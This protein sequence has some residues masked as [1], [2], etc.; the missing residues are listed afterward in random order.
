MLYVYMTFTT[1]IFHLS[2]FNI[3]FSSNNFNKKYNFKS[4]KKLHAYSKIFILFNW[5]LIGKKI[6]INIFETLYC[7]I[8]LSETFRLNNINQKTHQGLRLYLILIEKL[9]K[10]MFSISKVL[11]FFLCISYAHLKKYL[12]GMLKLVI[13][14]QYRA[15][16]FEK[17]K[18]V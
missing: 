3:E 5:T 1:I 18:I 15:E 4:W 10:S 8:Y 16:S 17:G 12:G 7:I 9:E 2:T 6:F 14:A 13:F 11:Q